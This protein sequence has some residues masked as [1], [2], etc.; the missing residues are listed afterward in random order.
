MYS[1]T[2]C[3]T[4]HLHQKK[5]YSQNYFLSL[6]VADQGGVDHPLRVLAWVEAAVS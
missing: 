5:H 6:D 1:N 3:Q 2:Y 4:L